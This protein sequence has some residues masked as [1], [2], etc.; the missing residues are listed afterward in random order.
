[1]LSTL[2]KLMS[3]AP[4]ESMTAV[5]LP[6]RIVNIIQNPPELEIREWK[7]FYSYSTLVSF[8]VQAPN[9]P[10]CIGILN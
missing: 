8:L 6:L 7:R 5:M 1:M 4:T 2:C 9:L 10:F 3:W